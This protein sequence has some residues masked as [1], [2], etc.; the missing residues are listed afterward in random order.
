MFYPQNPK[1]VRHL[2]NKND[3]YYIVPLVGKDK[4]IRSLVSIHRKDG[5]Y[6]QGSFAKDLKNPIVFNLFA[7]EKIIN[8]VAKQ[9]DVKKGKIIV[10]TDYLVWMP[11]TESFS[12][13]IPFHEVTVGSYKA[14]VRIDGKVFTKLTT[15]NPA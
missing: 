4:K 1:L 2:A 10:N 9:L 13:D 7:K 8:L 11:C 3:F 12:P 14:Y 6:R 5:R 15:G